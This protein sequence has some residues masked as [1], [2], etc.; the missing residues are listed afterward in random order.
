M[1]A[2]ALP[3]TLCRRIELV[4][5]SKNI[6][7]SQA[8]SFLLEKVEAP[9][10]LSR[11]GGSTCPPLSSDTEDALTG[12]LPLAAGKDRH[13]ISPAPGQPHVSIADSGAASAV[14]AGSIC[15]GENAGGQDEEGGAK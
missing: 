13:S 15:A 10:I 11:K 1:I 9:F 3:I 5:E 4:A 14:G 8:V 6:D 12:N 7:F 2:I